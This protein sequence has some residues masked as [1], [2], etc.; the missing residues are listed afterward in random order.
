MQS[1]TRNTRYIY[2]DVTFW[3]VTNGIAA[4]FTT[5]FALR[6]GASDQQVGFISAL[7]ALIYMLWYIPAGRLVESARSIR[8]T[9]L[10]SVFLLRL[11]YLLI[12][13]IPFLPASWRVTV[14]LAVIML[15]GIPLCVAN[16]AV[17]NMLADVIP[18]EKRP[19]VVSRR[20]IIISLVSAIAAALAGKLLDLLPMPVNYQWMF[21]IAF[22]FGNLSLAALSRLVV[23]DVPPKP[24]LSLHVRE[25]ARQMREMLSVVRA[26]PDFLRF[27]L[28]A[29]VLYTGLIYAWPLFSLWWVNG[30]KASE[31][32]LGLIAT[33]NLLMS[34]ASNFVWARIA[35]KK[36][37]RFC[38]VAGFAGVTIMPVI[39]A[40]LPSA[41]WLLLTE[42]F[43]G[44]IVP[45]MTLGIFN[46]MLEVS[47]IDRRPTYIAVYS[48]AI[49]A[50]TFIAPI[51]ATTI[52][53]PLFGVQL[54]LAL[55]TLLRLAA[56]AIVIVLLRRIR[57]APAAR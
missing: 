39:N 42:S 24:A 50:P 30:L 9:A 12:V 29:V 21:V 27:T 34:I 15:T 31:G 16:V 49:N 19:H 45:G 51:L 35:E 3:G 20:N 52:A 5:V 36:G 6:L 4:T 23:A 54:A 18:P 22:V 40:M 41:Q 44:L 7:P 10:V 32:L 55:S 53:A 46:T 56:L 17:T 48:A 1:F 43:A 28:A 38:M 37:N 13:L 57:P 25:F 47:P 8:K 26:S 14:L 33:A 2:L 11:Q